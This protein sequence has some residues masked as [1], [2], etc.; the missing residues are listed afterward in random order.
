MRLIVQFRLLETCGINGVFILVCSVE[1][2]VRKPKVPTGKVKTHYSH[3]FICV[4][5]KLSMHNMGTQLLHPYY[6]VAKKTPYSLWGM[7]IMET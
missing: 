2:E 6:L 1:K 4:I 3:Y 7:Y 5:L